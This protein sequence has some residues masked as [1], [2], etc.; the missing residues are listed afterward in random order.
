MIYRCSGCGQQINLGVREPG[1]TTYIYMSSIPA[2]C[3]RCGAPFS[4]RKMA[5]VNCGHIGAANEFVTHKTF[6][7][8]TDRFSLN[9]CPK[10]GWNIESVKDYEFV[11]CPECRNQ[12]PTLRGKT[13]GS[14][15][16]VNRWGIYWLFEKHLSGYRCPTC[17]I[18]LDASGKKID[19]LKARAKKSI[20]LG[21]L[22]I[23]TS[24]MLIGIFFSIFGIFTAVKSLVHKKYTGLAV[25]GLVLS[26]IGAVIEIFLIVHGI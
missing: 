4:N 2:V 8:Q 15:S 22:S 24:F 1:N 10:C 12:F 9:T 14:S 5:C 18:R 17:K 19:E 25:T 3:P 21:I 23:I 6:P 7:F 20:K 13:T 26:L 11:E 16:V